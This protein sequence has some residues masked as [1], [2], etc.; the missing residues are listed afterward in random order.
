MALR[1]RFKVLCAVLLCSVLGA[2]G[3]KGDLSL[4][5]E[6]ITQQELKQL[7]KPAQGV[8]ESDDGES[9]APGGDDVKDPGKK[10]S[11]STDN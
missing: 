6:G 1:Q 4:I 7:E 10:K 8:G 9:V 3:N 11:T 2:C 5:S